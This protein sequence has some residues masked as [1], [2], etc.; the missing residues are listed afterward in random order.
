MLGVAL[1]LQPHGPPASG[2]VH[3]RS[4]LGTGI[5]PGGHTQA[6]VV[7]PTSLGPSRSQANT[8]GGLQS[9]GLFWS[10][11]SQVLLK[12]PQVATVE[13]KTSVQEALVEGRWVGDKWPG[14]RSVCSYKLG[15]ADM[16]WGA[17]SPPGGGGILCLPF[18]AQSPGP[19]HVPMASGVAPGLTVGSSED[20]VHSKS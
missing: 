16:L 18:P 2:S 14:A 15:F 1:L 13:G 6:R 11:G 4:P 17:A 3:L 19:W 10:S 20:Q 7:P 9:R 5:P 8:H 12:C